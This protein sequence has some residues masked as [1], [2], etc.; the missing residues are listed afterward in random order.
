MKDG[1]LE[2]WAGIECTMNR[3]DES[4]F[5]QLRRSGHDRRADDI[6]RLAELGVRA[7]RY[8]FRWESLQPDLT[9]PP[10]FAWSDERVA[11]LGDVGMRPIA[12]LLHHGSGP[13]GTHLLDPMFATRFATFARAFAE[14][15]P[16]VEDYTPVNE[17][18]TTARFSGLYGIWFPHGT[19]DS[20]FVRC[21]YNE[22]RA[23]V[24]AMKAIR[25]VN[26]RARLVQ[27][28]DYGQIDGSD[29]L[30]EQIAHENERRFLGFDLL[31]GRVTREHP[32]HGY[33]VERGGLSEEELAFFV[34]N[35]CPP[36]VIGLDYYITSDRYL[37]LDLARHAPIYH[38]GNGVQRY[39]DVETVRVAPISGHERM[40]HTVWRRYQL[41]IAITEAH[42]GSTREEQ[43]RW[44]KEAW[45]ASQRARDDGVDVRA[46]TSW[47]ALGSY[48]WDCL[49][50][51]DRGHYEPGAF[52][53]RAPTPR[54]TAIAKMV[55]SLA[56]TGSFD[57][58]V[59][60]EDGWW[61]RVHRAPGCAPLVQRRKLVIVGAGTLGRALSRLCGMRGFEHVLLS[62]NDVDITSK[63]AVSH[64]LAQISPWAVINAAGYVRVDDA[65]HDADR[66]FA[67]NTTGAITLAEA[68]AERRLPFVTFS[69]DLV[70]DGA[71]SAPYVEKHAPA[72]L[73]VYGKSKALAEAEV[74]R[75]H[76]GALV[77]RTSAFF[78]PW[79]EANFVTIALRSLARGET[80]RAAEDLTVS[81]TYVPSLGG[82]CLDLLVD[83]EGGIWH[84]ANQGE[85]TWCDLARR[86]A[87]IA[88][89]PFHV[90]EGCR[91]AEL[92][93]VAPRPKYS[94]LGS[95]LHALMPDLDESL[96]DYL[97]E[98]KW[99]V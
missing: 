96:L 20:S 34:E 5:D 57:H 21:L 77:I 90:V 11:L 59:L 93:M 63:D 40:L 94:A 54:A 76:P 79:D 3:V 65:E 70:F 32:L 9:A 49:V 89:L 46:V 35:P 74:R 52:D 41:P 56:T 82:V 31:C 71:Q 86:A 51:L 61:R 55:K 80:F 7:V 48:D 69:S 88:R 99:C 28:E 43:L 29:A 92:G 24:L 60:D 87:R 17:P 10:Q 81:P 45:S 1:A 85:V 62:R 84:L 13:R 58:P 30:C 83:G 78:G 68:C 22:L 19:A 15:Y 2:I 33:L 39:A 50:T 27:T 73:S 42:M 64:A 72:P 95:E 75:I 4:F 36:D 23:T 44:F 18:L 26:P 98:M 66:C 97:R 8:P 25:D 67:W 37:D 6:R 53:V 12:G 91:A 16:S 14:R 47:A 38:G